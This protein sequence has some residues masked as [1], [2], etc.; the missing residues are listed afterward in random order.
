MVI[1]VDVAPMQHVHGLRSGFFHHAV[2]LFHQV[3]GGNRVEPRI[4]ET[5]APEPGHAI[6]ITHAI[7]FF[8]LALNQRGRPLRLVT[9]GRDGP[10]DVV[11]G[12]AVFQQRPSATQRLIVWVRR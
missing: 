12:G 2:Q 9:H 11:A 5:Q 7:H 6:G 4:R 3:G 1:G 10:E 8:G